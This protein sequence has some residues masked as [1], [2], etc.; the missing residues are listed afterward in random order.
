MPMQNG[1]KILK[2]LVLL[3]LICDLDQNN[4]Q[5]VIYFYFSV[6][7]QTLK[8][9]HRQIELHWSCLLMREYLYLGVTL[10]YRIVL[11]PRDKVISNH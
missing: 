8:T 3:P 10:G 1:V 6:L 5:I 2:R 11:L 7:L 9:S 4:S